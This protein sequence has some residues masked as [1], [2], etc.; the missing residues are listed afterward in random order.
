[1]LNAWRICG[2][3]GLKADFV[4]CRW[5]GGVNWA[6]LSRRVSSNTVRIHPLSCLH[7]YGLTPAHNKL[8]RL[9]IPPSP[10]DVRSA[11]GQS[12]FRQAPIRG[13]LSKWLFNGY[14]RIAGHLPY[15]VPP[16]AIGEL[17][18]FS[19][20]EALSFWNHVQY[21]FCQDMPSTRTRNVRTLIRTA[22]QVTLLRWRRT[23]TTIRANIQN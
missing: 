1:M 18:S 5:D 19:F 17:S 15:V 6:A 9:E 11:L 20:L 3:Y 16:V 7:V 4:V 21:I 2:S 8:L 13:L 22:K 14:S 12:P 10:H 23:V